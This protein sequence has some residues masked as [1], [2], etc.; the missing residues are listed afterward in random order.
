LSISYSKAGKKDYVGVII[1]NTSKEA[2]ALTVGKSSLK[3]Y[4]NGYITVDDLLAETVKFL[5][6]LSDI[7]AFNTSQVQNR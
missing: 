5:I 4:I 2:I 6:D 3:K 1:V 7:P